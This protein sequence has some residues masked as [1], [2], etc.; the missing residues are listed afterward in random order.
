MATRLQFTSG[1][2]LLEEWA[3]AASQAER[4]VVYEAL[5]S[6]ADG[7]AFMIYDIFGDSENPKHFIIVV[8]RNLVLKFSMRRAESAFDLLYVGALQGGMIAAAREEEYDET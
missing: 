6:V 7:S 2:D 3:Q 4:N 8:K 5:F 1:F